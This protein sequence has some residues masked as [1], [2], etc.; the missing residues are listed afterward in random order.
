AAGG[1]AGVGLALAKWLVEAMHGRIGLDSAPG[2]GSCFWVSLERTTAEAGAAPARR[3]VLYVEDNAL[4][5]AAQP[6]LVL[7]DIQLPDADGFELLRR[8]RARSET[9]AIPV[10]AVSADAMPE[11]IAA[12]RAAGFAD[13]LTKPLEQGRLLEAVDRVLDAG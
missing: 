13:Y 6:A 4:A 10:V 7:L 2:L 3:T 5:V 12:A 11:R 9:E 1:G 8:L